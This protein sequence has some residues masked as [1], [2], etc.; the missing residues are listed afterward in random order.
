[1]PI[2][3][4]DQGVPL[5]A[6]TDLAD[7]PAAFSNFYTPVMSRL[8]LRYTSR[9]N[10]TL[11]H[12]APIL[13]ETSIIDGET[14]YERWTGAKWIPV[15]PI[16]A[17]KGADQ[18]VNNSTAL[19]NATGLVVPLPA[20]NTLYSFQIWASYMSSTVADIKFTCTIPA[21]ATGFIGG[22]GLA[23]TGG[24]GTGGDGEWGLV[25]LPNPLAFGGAAAPLVV[26]LAGRV[27]VNATTGSLQVQFAQNTLEVSNTTLFAI[28]YMSVEAVL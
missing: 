12:P 19:V 3:D 14:W 23:T 2:I 24:G 9:A 27:Q 1:M 28:S 22:A 26:Q 6:G 7:N 11:L 13:N 25:G 18:N 4:P 15:T 21:G 16:K 8:I 20:A 17:S 10:R 5:P